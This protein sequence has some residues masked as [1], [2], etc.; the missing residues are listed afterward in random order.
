MAKFSIQLCDPSFIAPEAMEQAFHWQ[1]NEVVVFQGAQDSRTLP[2]DANGRIAFNTD[3]DAPW[4]VADVRR[5]V[6]NFPYAWRMVDQ[7]SPIPTLLPN[8]E[9]KA[10]VSAR[11][12][13]SLWTG[14]APFTKRVSDFHKLGATIPSA[15]QYEAFVSKHCAGMD[16][17]SLL[18]TVAR[19]PDGSVGL[20]PELAVFG[21][22]VG[23]KDS[24]ARKTVER[25]LKNLVAGCHACGVQVN[26]GYEVRDDGSEHSKGSYVAFITSPDSDMVDHATR[27]SDFAAQWDFDGIGFDIEINGIGPSE[28][29]DLM[30]AWFKKGKSIKDWVAERP[31]SSDPAARKEEAAARNIKLLYQTLAARLA[32]RDRF[33]S[34]ATAA[35]VSKE[36]GAL[37][38]GVHL[39]GHI[40][41]QPLNLAQGHPN[42]LARIMAYDE[43]PQAGY[44]ADGPGSK[45]S[46]TQRHEQ[47]LKGVTGGG[48]HPS[49]IQL[50]IKMISL[51]KLGMKSGH[52]TVEQL[53]ERCRQ[54]RAYRTGM[55]AFS[56][57]LATPAD[58][59]AS[60]AA[61]DAILNDKEFR[62]THFMGVPFQ[63]PHGS[64]TM[65]PPA[66][67]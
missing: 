64:V 7:T 15:A 19:L 66:A 56:G 29:S 53:K 41:V 34:Y 14:L 28:K 17:I 52:M 20:A 55:I 26:A 59:V 6:R 16:D 27:L 1:D 12:R 67:M 21:Q 5:R 13:L 32:T 31:S 11:A 33:V 61:Y 35:F 57:S 8:V 25:A 62:R 49:A 54:L 51:Q 37:E 10:T 24:A 43:G 44:G 46:L 63:A 48:I 47:I 23:E 4:H 22:T 36:T 30:K 40:R 2:A 38:D 3:S 39:F 9:F 42:L 60:F 65:R 58:E 45:D 18:A 50:G